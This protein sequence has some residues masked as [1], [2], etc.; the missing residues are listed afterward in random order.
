MGLMKYLLHVLILALFSCGNN[1]PKVSS[2]ITEIIS[3]GIKQDVFDTAACG[4]NFKPGNNYSQEKDE[5]ELM[6]DELNRGYKTISDST[7]KVHFLDSSMA[8]FTHCLLDKI[9][10]Y[11][12]GTK[13]NF[14]GH[15]AIPNEGTI[16]CGYFV[17]TTLRDMGL[18]INRYRLAQQGPEEEAASLA[19]DRTK[20]IVIDITPADSDS[21]LFLKKLEPGLYMVGLDYHV[22]YL[23]LKDDQSYFI[24]SNYIDGRVMIENTSNSKA[25]ESTRYF[26]SKITRNSLLAKKWLSGEKIDVVMTN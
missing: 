20:M 2:G 26:I 16:A 15:S 4:L 12:Y 24:H 1:P 6:R 8:V 7:L 21:T 10:P 13:W 23:Y 11:W 5:I 14:E 18:N 19:I 22:G 25:F 3:V 17:S 9:V